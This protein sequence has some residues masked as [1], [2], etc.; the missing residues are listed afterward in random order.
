MNTTD[1]A[2][3]AMIA[4]RIVENKDADF[5]Y[6]VFCDGRAWEFA[7]TDLSQ[8]EQQDFL[9][10][11]YVLQSHGYAENFPNAVHR[12]ITRNGVDVGRIIFDVHDDH[13]HI[14][15]LSILTAF[16]R[17]GIGG[18]VML[19]MMQEA[20]NG[21]VPVRLHVARLSPAQRLYARLGFEIKQE[22]GNHLALEWM[23]EI[24]P[25]VI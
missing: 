22:V 17:Q 1:G 23:P 19:G 25:A 13:L 14:I 16:Q 9:K 7:V 5:I 12:I 6:K 8:A 2:M 10:G 11:Q 18:D 21:R 15:D 20:R 24:G 4:F 3:R